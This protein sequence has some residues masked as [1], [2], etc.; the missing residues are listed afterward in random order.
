MIS[1]LTKLSDDAAKR[2]SDYAGKCL[3]LCGLK[4]LSEIAGEFFQNFGGEISDQKPK[5][6]VENFASK[7]H[8]L[9]ISQ[10]E[11]VLNSESKSGFEKIYEVEAEINGKV[12]RFRQHQTEKFGEFYFYDAQ[13]TKLETI[14]NLKNGQLIKECLDGDGGLDCLN[15]GDEWDESFG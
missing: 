3:Y 6:W 1:G 10:P 5:E 2:L 13:S 7:L 8:I 4:W 14:S 12:I 9:V 11:M 15:M